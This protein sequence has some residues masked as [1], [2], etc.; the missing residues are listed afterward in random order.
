MSLLWTCW[1]LA[2]RISSISVVASLQWRLFWCWQIR[3]S[4]YSVLVFDLWQWYAY[5]MVSSSC[6]VSSSLD[7]W[8][9]TSKLEN[10][11][12]IPPWS[13]VASWYLR[14]CNYFTRRFAVNSH[15]QVHILNETTLHDVH[16]ITH[17]YTACRGPEV[18]A[19]HNINLGALDHQLL[20][21]FSISS[22]LGRKCL[23]T[24][25]LSK[26]KLTSLLSRG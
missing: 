5:C 11:A 4:I 2:L 22:S 12:Q 14:H 25:S 1:D 16:N 19:R 26:T 21:K 6:S 18:Q 10:N 13:D 7:I 8:R 15:F 23:G 24:L 20:S 17:M 3:Y 9:H